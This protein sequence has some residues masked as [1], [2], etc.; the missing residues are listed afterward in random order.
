MKIIP[1]I[2]L[3]I[4]ALSNRAIATIDVF[5]C[6]DFKDSLSVPEAEGRRAWALKCFPQERGSILGHKAL[7]QEGKMRAAYPTFGIW[8]EDG[9]P[10]NPQN[11]F[12]PTD[13]AESCSIPEGY[14]I[15]SFCVR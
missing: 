11:W 3:L 2:A 15:L 10:T 1:I 6:E 13:E 7:T 9:T 14:D 8:N 5:R 4:T 12:A